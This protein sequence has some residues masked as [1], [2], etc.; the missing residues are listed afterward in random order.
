VTVALAG[1]LVA[2]ASAG[3]LVG[4]RVRGRRRDVLLARAS[5]ELRGPLQAVLFGLAGLQRGP[6]VPGPALD[7]RARAIEAEL[8]RVVVALADLDAARSR[9]RPPASPRHASQVDVA[10]L[11]RAQAATWAPLAAH[12]GRE[13]VVRADRPVWVVG[14]PGRLAQATGNLI[15]NAVRHGLGTIS[16]TVEPTED[17]RVRIEVADE[18]A[19][20]RVPLERL[21]GRSAGPRDEH[22]HGLAVAADVARRHGGRLGTAPGAP[23]C[24]LVLDL[25]VVASRAAA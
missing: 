21:L 15:A 10:G 24:R 4:C 18:G 3:T 2:L 20:L 9:R 12:S 17:A 19:G 7:E 1:W 14:D 23:G 8:G 5:H 13:L 6:A 22:G 16:V 25:P 11:V